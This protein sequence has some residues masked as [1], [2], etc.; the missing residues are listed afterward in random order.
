MLSTAELSE[1]LP[2]ALDYL[3]MHGAVV[4][5]APPG[6]G[7]M[8]VPFSLLPYPFPATLL[9]RAEALAPLFNLL[10]DAVSRDSAW[11]LSTLSGA[12]AADP[13]TGRLV[14]LHREELARQAAADA[15]AADAAGAAGLPLQHPLRLGLH[16]SDY[17]LTV[18]SCG[19]L[20]PTIKQVEL[21]TVAS[22]MAG[23]ASAVSGLHAYLEARLAP[24]LPGLRAHLALA[25]AGAA[26]LSPSPACQRLAAGLA[27]AHAAYA[28]GRPAAA[29]ATPLA[30]LFVV[31]PGERNVFDQ[32]ALEKELWQAHAIPVLRLTLLELAQQQQQQPAATLP[33]SAA[34]APALLLP[35]LTAGQHCEVS[36]VYYRAGY[37]PSDYPSEAEWQGRAAAE[38]SRAIKCP[39]LAYHLAGT[40]KVQQALAL[41]GAVEKFFPEPPEAPAAVAP[42]AAA[43]ALRQCFAGLWSLDPQEE[44]A[45]V[46]AAV[47][48]AR[49]S[50]CDYVV[51]P[52]R[53][54]GGNNLY[55]QAVAEALGGGMG[56]AERAGHIL[57]ERLHPPAQQAL[58]V[59]GG[60][61]VAAQ[62]TCELG[63]YGVF[64]GAGGRAAPLL[65]GCGGTLLRTK[66]E[67]SDEGGV[68]AGF[69]VI[70]SVMPV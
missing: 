5:Q 64:L 1:L 63:V 39:C 34:S 51:K 25:G 68:A 4:N 2:H 32:R 67:S 23:H 28:S 6:V 37:A 40:K 59:R 8:H 31:Q 65:N 69:A 7:A 50:P 44:D 29:A 66:V 21:N 60:V 45:G 70:D 26:P 3:Y 13:F 46:R 42:A 58:M 49:S 16:R 41:P 33:H 56:A 35:A 47:A 62:A 17:M 20:P 15:A 18:P 43:A 38:A 24:H 30:I 36:V 10:V 55:G 12:A 11:L 54:G 52:Q 53:E 9:A 19:T 14:A 27:A 48:A 61:V 22:S 57:M